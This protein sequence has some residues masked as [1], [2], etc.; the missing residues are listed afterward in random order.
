MSPVVQVAPDEIT[1][2]RP[3]AVQAIA[4]AAAQINLALH[5]ARAPVEQ[6]GSS[7]GR[8]ISNAASIQSL[9]TDADAMSDRLAALRL[10]AMRATVALQFYDRMTQHLTHLHD[11]LAGASELLA[12][13]RVGC[14]E[15]TAG[16]SPVQPAGWEALRDRLRS[17]LITE[18]QRQLL[19]RD[20]NL[21]GDAREPAARDAA[22]PP[23]CDS[24]ELF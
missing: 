7:V 21:E 17:R 9:G 5:E 2:A 18:S 19:Q 24:I 22:R 1:A 20:L 6:L 3:H 16:A 12:P 10:D 14:A 13:P 8:I 4:A 11:Y 15:T 23:A